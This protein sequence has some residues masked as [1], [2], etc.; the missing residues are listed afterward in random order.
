M[1]F[2]IEGQ[3]GGA[4][5]DMYDAFPLPSV[6]FGYWYWFG[7]SRILSRLFVKRSES[8]SVLLSETKLRNFE[9]LIFFF[10][11]D[12]LNVTRVF[13]VCREFDLKKDKS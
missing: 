5:S 1:K 10:F 11:F 4:R 3:T 7:S 9:I 8:N 6:A 12:P 2:E 13:T